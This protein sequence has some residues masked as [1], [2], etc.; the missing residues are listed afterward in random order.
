[1][2]KDY[3][4][5]WNDSPCST[6][7][8]GMPYHKC[9]ASVTGDKEYMPRAHLLRLYADPP[10]AHLKG[11]MSDYNCAHGQFLNTSVAHLLMVW[12]VR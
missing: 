5:G 3:E 6:S 4:L 9:S 12:E 2:G 10:G 11:C 8:I 7:V 1:M